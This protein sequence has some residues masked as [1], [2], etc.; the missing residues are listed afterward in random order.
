MIAFSN[1]RLASIAINLQV[2]LRLAHT[3][4]KECVNTVREITKLDFII[5]LN[6][7]FYTVQLIKASASNARN[8]IVWNAVLNF[9]QQ[10]YVHIVS[11][12]VKLL[13]KS[14]LIKEWTNNSNK[15]HLSNH[16][17]T[18][19]MWIWLIRTANMMPMRLC[20]IFLRVSFIRVNLV[21]F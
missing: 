1:N 14:K 4:T 15:K 20:L 16:I 10:E 8:I 21:L 6:A 18:I 12:K 2:I 7:R 3:V 11:Y 13:S 19:L 5:A 17:N 9:R